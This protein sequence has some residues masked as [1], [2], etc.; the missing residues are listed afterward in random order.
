M[1]GNSNKGKPTPKGSAKNPYAKQNMKPSPL[2]NK[3]DVLK[4][5]GLQETKSP[6][7]ELKQTKVDAISGL[8]GES[9]VRTARGILTLIHDNISGFIIPLEPEELFWT[10]DCVF[11]EIIGNRK[12]VERLLEKY[13]GKEDND[14]DPQ[15]LEDDWFAN[16]IKTI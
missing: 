2:A 10:R 9:A 15:D 6:N 3:S 4:G 14:N 11:S 12:A 1:A 8:E 7:K 5:L 16:N 13:S